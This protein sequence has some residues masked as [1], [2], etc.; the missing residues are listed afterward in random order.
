M[1]GKRFAMWTVHEQAGNTPGGGALWRCTCDCGTE[2]VVLGADIRKGKSRNCGCV[3]QS[4]LGN[5]KRSHAATGTRL[6][7]IW[8]LVLYRCRDTS[9]PDYGGRGISVCEEWLT[10]EP[11]R[12]WALVN[13][14]SDKLSIERV[15]VDGNYCPENCTWADA[16][17][18][19]ANRRYT[20]KAP[21]GELW[22]HK[23][24]KNGITGVAF[25]QRVH[26]GWPMEQAIT[27]PMN[28]ERKKRP[29]NHKGQFA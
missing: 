1:S 13:G 4:R 23:A 19:S 12:A 22:L 6:Y 2:R 8:K 15:D 25:R 16:A 26:A 20:Q 10:F 14:Y 28:T 24:R 17:T 27:W 11:F 18:Q 29:R 3:T 21:D 5:M 9:N 7:N